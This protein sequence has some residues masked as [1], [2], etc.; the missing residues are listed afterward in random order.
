MKEKAN[1]RCGMVGGDDPERTPAGEEWAADTGRAHM[2]REKARRGRFG[3][4]V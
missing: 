2:A 1:L 4:W 3:G